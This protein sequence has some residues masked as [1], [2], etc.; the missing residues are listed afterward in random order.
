MS[1]MSLASPSL[2][3]KLEKKN[4]KLPSCDFDHSS[5]CRQVKV[6]V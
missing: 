5:L 2:T 4:V 3:S 1:D 6:S